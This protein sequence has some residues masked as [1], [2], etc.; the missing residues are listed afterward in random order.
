MGSFTESYVFLSK[1]FHGE[2]RRKLQGR[3]D[4]HFLLEQREMVWTKTSYECEGGF[5][6]PKERLFTE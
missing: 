3:R 4:G 2:T 5:E 1:E 6:H